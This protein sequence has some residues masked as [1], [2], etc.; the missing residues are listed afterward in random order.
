MLQFE[1]NSHFHHLI[2]CSKANHK[3]VNFKKNLELGIDDLNKHDLN[4]RC[5][6]IHELLM[7]IN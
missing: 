3:K 2:A 1:P 7:N 4:W 6:Y 5:F